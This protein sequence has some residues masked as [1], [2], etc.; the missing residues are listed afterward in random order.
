MQLLREPEA[1]ARGLRG[2]EG[3]FRAVQ[4]SSGVQGV[5]GGSG[6]AGRFRG[7]QGSKTWNYLLGNLRRMPLS[8]AREVCRG[9]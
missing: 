3:R 7:V 2:G 5:Q 6:G 9:P 8:A 1:R 4:G